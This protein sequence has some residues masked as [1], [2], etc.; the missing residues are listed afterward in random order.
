MIAR[1]MNTALQ[2]DSDMDEFGIAATLLPLST[3]FGRKL[4]KGV[5]QFLYTLIQVHIRKSAKIMKKII[6]SVHGIKAFLL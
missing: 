3:V 5:V 1:L 6:F 4:G 2:D